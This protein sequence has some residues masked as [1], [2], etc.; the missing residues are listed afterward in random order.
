MAAGAVGA[1][2]ALAAAV[3][4]LAAAPWWQATPPPHLIAL[5]S[6]PGGQA[7]AIAGGQVGWYRPSSGRFT[8]LALGDRG[9]GRPVLVASRLGV[10]AVAYQGGRVEVLVPGRAPRLWGSVPGS[11]GAIALGPG[12]RPMLAVASSRGLFWAR[13][14]QRPR[15]AGPGAATAV[16]A[17]SRAGQPWVALVRG[18]VLERRAGGWSRVRGAPRLPAATRALAELGSGVVLVCQPSGLVWR[19][20]GRDWTAAFQILPQ[21]G[22]EGVPQVTALVGDGPSAAYLA[23]RGFGTLLT[24]DGGYTWY[25]A[26]P[27]SSSVLGL[28]AV[29]P[30]FSTR[31]PAGYVLALS[32]GQTFRH[33]LQALPA[34]PP[35]QG[36]Q[37]ELQL[38]LTAAVTAGCGLVVMALLAWG[39]RR[40]RRLSV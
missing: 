24:P 21:G 36:G 40:R 4:A 31:H 27:P 17:P 14:G 33:R 3:P 16:V 15:R 2:L 23:T 10:G 1:C 8:P 29:G 11:L 6:D 22:L 5:S 28:A 13:L 12:A 20:S 7:L 34:P 18:R 30:V 26:S 25:R 9:R 38:A 37:L 35:Y 19:G 39:F 32:A